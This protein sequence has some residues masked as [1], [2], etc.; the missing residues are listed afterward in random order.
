MRAVATQDLALAVIRK[1]WPDGQEFTAREL[2][3]AMG[4][5]RRDRASNALAT[6]TAK[7]VVSRRRVSPR[8]EPETQR[9]GALTT[10]VYALA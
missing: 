6:L 10:F 5:D 7:R 9:H 4:V 2:A 8:R 1:N 3:D